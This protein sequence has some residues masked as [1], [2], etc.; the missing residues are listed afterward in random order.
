MWFGMKVMVSSSPF[1]SASR[2]LVLLALR[3]LS[4][5]YPRELSRVLGVPLSAVQRALLGLER[6]GL[7]VARSVGRTRVFEINRRYFAFDDLQRFLAR[8]AEP[9]AELH[10]SVEAL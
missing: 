10:R 3:L 7:V 2:T 6:D 4:A 1:G 5:S 8:L 9:E